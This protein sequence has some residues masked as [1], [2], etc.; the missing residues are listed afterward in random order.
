MQFHEV[1]FPTA[2]SFGSIGGPER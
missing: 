2:L 1:R